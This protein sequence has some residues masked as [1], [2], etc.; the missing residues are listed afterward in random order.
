MAGRPRVDHAR[1]VADLHARLDERLTALAASDDWL[2]YLATVRTTGSDSSVPIVRRRS[3]G[4][5]QARPFHGRT[6]AY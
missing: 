4:E 3:G 2:D 5:H 6:C 1:L